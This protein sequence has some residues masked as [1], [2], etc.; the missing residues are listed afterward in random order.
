[1]HGGTP[2]TKRKK[3]LFLVLYVQFFI[4]ALSESDFF[5]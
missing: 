4:E 5:K 1:M 2:K 3:I